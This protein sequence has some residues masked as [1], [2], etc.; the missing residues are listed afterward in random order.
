MHLFM[1]IQNITLELNFDL[2]LAEKISE[3]F[4]LA[5]KTSHF[6]DF[7]TKV[8]LTFLYENKLFKNIFYQNAQDRK[9]NQH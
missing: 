6:W 4:F 3:N 1:G 2:V 8:F 9:L 5:C 7:V